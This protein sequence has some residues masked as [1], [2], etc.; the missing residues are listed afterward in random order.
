VSYE[1]QLYARQY[2]KMLA[3]EKDKANKKAI[4]VNSGLNETNFLSYYAHELIASVPESVSL[5]ELSIFPVTQ[6]ITK[7]EAF[8]IDNNHI[9]ITG[10]ALDNTGFSK[11]VLALQNKKWTDKVEIISMESEENRSIF[12]LKI[13]L[14]HAL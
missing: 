1:K 5:K 11:W 7:G 14:Y 10:N 13:A 9:L 8:S 2:Q 3:L 4:L 12:K 6:K